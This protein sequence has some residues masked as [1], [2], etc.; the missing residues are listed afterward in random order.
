MVTRKIAVANQKGGVGKTTTS[1]SL[2]TGL[3][4]LGYKPLLIDADSQ[5]NS[6]DTYRAAIKDTATL[7]DLLFENENV[8]DCIQVTETGSII[9]CDPLMREAEQRFPND[10]SRGFLLR[11][12]CEDLEGM[13]DFI[14]IDTPPT[15][16]VVL[17][18]VFTFADEILIP[19]TC[20]RYA[21]S[22]LDL[23]SQTIA[24][25]RKYTNPALK[26]TGMVLI[27]Y[28]ERQGLSREI[29]DG[30]P[31]IAHTFNTKVFDTKI[32][33]SVACKKSQ[34]ARMS[35]YDYDE[36]CTTAQDYLNLCKELTNSNR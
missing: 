12:K 14:I 18:N 3:R 1:V 32:R 11:E 10:N 9:P 19:L 26:V 25:A 8:L 16:G 23:L 24:S 27:K 5:C 33:E 30:L 4:K 35:I 34:S 29:K 13:Y 15:M 31:S 36:S 6:S 7:Y 17:S 21:L 20:D 22:G 2:A 28:A